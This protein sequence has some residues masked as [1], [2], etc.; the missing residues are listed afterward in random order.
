[1]MTSSQLKVPS[2]QIANKLEASNPK[3]KPRYMRDTISRAAKYRPK[4]S[5]TAARSGFNNITEKSPN[6]PA[7]SSELWALPGHKNRAYN[8]I[9]SRYAQNPK[10]VANRIQNEPEQSMSTDPVQLQNESQPA[11]PIQIRLSKFKDQSTASVAEQSPTIVQTT[12][13]KLDTSPM[14]PFEE[15]SFCAAAQSS[16]D[17]FIEAEQ[18]VTNKHDSLRFSI[19]NQQPPSPSDSQYQVAPP[20]FDKTDEKLVNKFDFRQVTTVTDNHDKSDQIRS[21]A[22]LLNVKPSFPSN[23]RKKKNK[24]NKEEEKK[25]KQIELAAKQRMDAKLIQLAAKKSIDEKRNKERAKIRIENA[26]KCKA[27][28]H[29]I[30]IKMEKFKH[31]K[32][33]KI[34]AWK[35]IRVN[36][37]RE[38]R[39]AKLKRMR[40]AEE[41]ALPERN[42][43]DF[44]VLTNR[45]YADASNVSSI[46]T[47]NSL[48]ILGNG[49]DFTSKYSLTDRLLGKGGM[50]SVFEGTRV[51]DNI[52]VAI[53]KIEKSQTNEFVLI[54]GRRYPMEYCL[55]YQVSDCDGVVS[56]LEAFETD[57]E[58]ILVMELMPSCC[59]LESWIK[60][61]GAMSE[62][63]AKFFFRN[64]VETVGDCH[65]LGVFH[66]DLKESNILMDLKNKKKPKLI[67]F[68][69]SAFIN[70]SPYDDMAKG[71]YGYMSPEMYSYAEKYEGLPAAVYS[72]GVVLYDII[73]GALIWNPIKA[74]H[75][76]VVPNVT[77]ECLDLLNA[78]LEQYPCDR[79]HFDEILQHPWIRL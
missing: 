70:D 64:L 10:L 41:I 47:F 34:L 59:S 15:P 30:N 2:A 12:I 43:S 58:F 77:T 57:D 50:G 17:A 72:L 73:F 18:A 28:L 19:F 76:E 61:R 49:E 23:N 22:H 31:L 6:F 9:Q 65:R 56:L 26:A 37:K 36:L 68:G 48:P 1:M 29:T 63:F 42:C 55:Y 7:I 39:A 33:K 16:L 71:T 27:E 8:N 5:I 32:E 40:N 35:I 53:K 69:I 54:N 67:D 62:S 4:V 11:T 14:S 45:N 52:P 13:N 78:M 3:T 21:S 44:A 51:T 79:I 60:Q 24:I 20:I 66:R 46:S 38:R 74:E 25:V 75:D